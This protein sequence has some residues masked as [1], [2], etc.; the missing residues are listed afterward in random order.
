MRKSDSAE[1]EAVVMEAKSYDIDE[2]TARKIISELLRRGVIYEKEYGHVKI[3][4]E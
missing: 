2:N 1:V 4:G 3:V